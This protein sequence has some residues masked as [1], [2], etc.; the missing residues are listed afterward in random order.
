[1]IIRYI[2]HQLPGRLL[3]LPIF[4]LGML[5]LLSACGT[6][7]TVTDIIPD[8]RP[9]YRTSASTRPLEV[10][11]DLTASTLD[12]A[13]QVPDLAS[14]DSATLSAYSEE[15]QTG[16]PREPVAHTPD[17]FQVER[18]GDRRW[19]ISN[20]AAEQLWP[21]VRA[22]WVDN[23]FPLSRDEPSIG[24]LETDW[25]ENRA[26]ISDGPVRAL[27]SRFLDFAY[28][29]P[30]RDRFRVRLER[31]AEGTEIYLTHYG[32]EEQLVASGSGRTAT[33]AT[34]TVWQSRPRDPELEAEMLTRLMVYLG[35]AE[36]SARDALATEPATPS[37]ERPRTRQI[38]NE[39]GEQA[40][41]VEQDYNET[42]RRVGLTLDSERFVVD[43]QNRSE[44]LYV[45]ER[46]DTST[47]QGSGVL[48]R[49]AF[50]R[51]EGDTSRERTGE[52]FRV[53]LAGQGAQTLVVIHDLD[54][55]VDNS[56]E[57]LALLEILREALQ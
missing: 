32:V 7:G 17:G 46:I 37:G 35:T 25:L 44:G 6:V 8:R 1:M 9:D 53:R 29:A 39:L 11:P 54:G 20:Q 4:V 57:G 28:S 45:V 16:L 2:F 5:L 21:R 36:S 34:T 14:R 3:M 41:L 26:D 30:T 10:P 18:D 48:S 33:E 56:P 52:R 27:L 31:V 13:L 43:D 12:D 42:W 15:R 40:L 24:V 23:G 49:L 22:F 47:Q 50:W 38:R 55:T 51:S 19:L